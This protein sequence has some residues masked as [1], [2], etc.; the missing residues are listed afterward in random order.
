MNP[1]G[2]QRSPFLLTVALALLVA[3]AGCNLPGGTASPA[4]DEGVTPAPVPESEYPPGLGTAGV[5]DAQRLAT[6]HATAVENRSLAVRYER[7]VVLAN[8]S[9]ATWSRTRVRMAEGW[10]RFAGTTARGG[11]RES[12]YRTAVF[13]NNTR[14][15]IRQSRGGE[16]SYRVDDSPDALELWLVER[17]LP[18]LML[19]FRRA[20][21]DRTSTDPLRFRVTGTVD[22]APDVLREEP[23]GNATATAVIGGDGVIRRVRVAYDVEDPRSPG[24]GRIVETIEIRSLDDTTVA[25][26]DWAAD[27]VAAIR[28]DRP[29]G[30]GESRV[31]DP[32]ALVE[33]HRAALAGDQLQVNRELRATAPDSADSELLRRERAVVGGERRTFYRTVDVLREEGAGPSNYDVWSNRTVAVTERFVNESTAR[34]GIRE[35]VAF[36]ATNAVGPPERDLRDVLAGLGEVS[37]EFRDRRY[38]VVAESVADPGLVVRGES[39]SAA[40]AN[41][42]A[43]V[44]V[45]REGAIDGVTIEYDDL[46]EDSRIVERLDYDDVRPGPVPQP[47]WVRAELQDRDGELTVDGE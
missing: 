26:P 36:S 21:V 45:T 7:R 4:P 2:V 17:R 18:E 43:T 14:R 15:F 11:V 25:T 3:L 29:A 38:A 23:A 12:G 5:Q 19:A 6:T 22:N 35:P 47:S 40:V 9:T 42:S 30:L 16:T 32:D 41:V 10:D 24:T 39:G 44:Y 33:D 27:A 37:V 31:T 46:A 28:A 34:Y 13:A 8:G 20:T 1:L